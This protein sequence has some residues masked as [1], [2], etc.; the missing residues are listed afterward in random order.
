MSVIEEDLPITYSCE[1]VVI[2]PLQLPQQQQLQQPH[3]DNSTDIVDVSVAEENNNPNIADEVEVGPALTA[4][5]EA[6]AIRTYD[7]DDLASLKP[8]A[9]TPMKK[10]VSDPITSQEKLSASSI[11]SP[12]TSIAGR[13]S[14]AVSAVAGG[15]GQLRA[16]PNVGT[17]PSHANSSM[18]AP[19]G[20]EWRSTSFNRNPQQQGR[21]P[22]LHSYASMGGRNTPPTPQSNT[23]VPI[24]DVFKFLNDVIGRSESFS[25][26]PDLEAGLIGSSSGAAVAANNNSS[27]GGDEM[28]ETFLCR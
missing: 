21:Y 5:I 18:A 11:D 3:N 9:P 28:I 27:R 23:M 10:A 24:E 14:N 7:L 22:F 12:S 6:P 25:T 8:T 13:G 2:S 15:G 16:F 26:V 1:G 4:Q 20:R 19:I 17:N